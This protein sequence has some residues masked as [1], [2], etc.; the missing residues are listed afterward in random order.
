MTDFDFKKETIGY[1]ESII[2]HKIPDLMFNHQKMEAVKIPTMFSEK[3]K[4]FLQQEA[5]K[6]EIIE[7]LSRIELKINTIVDKK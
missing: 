7:M 4:D 2:E 5:E 3:Q 6:S 1:V